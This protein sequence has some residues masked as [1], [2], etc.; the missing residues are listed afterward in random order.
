MRGV[1]RVAN[2]SDR[3]RLFFPQF[4]EILGCGKGSYQTVLRLGVFF[5]L[6]WFWR[7]HFFWI[8]DGVHRPMI[9][10]HKLMKTNSEIR[11]FPSS[12]MT[13]ETHITICVLAV[14]VNWHF[15]FEDM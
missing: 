9:Q 5:C 1:Y 10:K 11:W 2:I 14:C 8:L 6:V 3:K 7:W 13:V 12:D 15:Q 4:G